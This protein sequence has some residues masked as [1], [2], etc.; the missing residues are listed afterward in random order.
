MAMPTAK[1]TLM[2]KSLLVLGMGMALVQLSA[3]S[4]ADPSKELRVAAASSLAGAF[5]SIS[6]EFTKESGVKVSLILSSSGNLTQQITEGAPYDLFA[7]ANLSYLN[8]LEKAKAV[9]ATERAIYAE[10]R[11]VMWVKKGSPPKQ[12]TELSSDAYEHIAIANPEY[13]PYGAAAR[14]AMTKAGIWSGIEGK[15]VRGANVRQAMQYVESGNAEVGFIALSLALHGG[16]SYTMIDDSLHQPLQQGIAVVS[17][18]KKKEQARAFIQFLTS[19]T[20]AA[21]LKPY[22]LQAA[23]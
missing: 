16:G 12:L 5:E 9:D 2:A 1:T 7:S 23:N 17:S 21:L 10:G 3:C 20:G 11:V 6:K 18:S 15:V 13:A 4:K 22:G 14:E 8:Q 19:K